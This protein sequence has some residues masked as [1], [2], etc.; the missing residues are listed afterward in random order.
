MLYAVSCSLH[1]YLNFAGYPVHQLIIRYL[2]GYVLYCHC[3]ATKGSVIA[4]DVVNSHTTV[5]AEPAT[6]GQRDQNMQSV[7]AHRWLTLTLVVN[8][9]CQLIKALISYPA[10]GSST[11]YLS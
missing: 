8:M 9:S 10:K 5:F 11:G 1:A 3:I 7:S 2:L 4:L 6:I